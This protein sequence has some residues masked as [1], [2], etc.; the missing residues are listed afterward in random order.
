MLFN[1]PNT[2]FAGIALDF[3]RALSKRRHIGLTCAS[4]YLVAAPAEFMAIL[5]FLGAGNELQFGFL[6]QSP[7][8]PRTLFLNSGRSIAR[9]LY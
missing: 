9:R 8:N 2:I 4:V 5:Y 6:L 3:K 7:D 1:Y